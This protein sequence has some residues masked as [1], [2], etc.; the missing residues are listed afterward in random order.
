[1]S[2]S[3]DL[4]EIVKQHGDN[5]LRALEVRR[6]NLDW[7]WKTIFN[8]EKSQN[9]PYCSIENDPY[10]SIENDPYCSIDM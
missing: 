8:T 10:C 5:F 2:I 3:Q 6:S 9:D 1:M 4:V 7:F